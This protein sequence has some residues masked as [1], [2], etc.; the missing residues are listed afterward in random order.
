MYKVLL[1]DDEILDLEGMKTFIPWEELGLEVVGAVNSGFAAWEIID[2]QK[3]DILVT[4]VRMPNMTGL[5]LARKAI[6]RWDRLRVIFVSGYQDF[7]YL[8]QALTLNAYNYVLKPM[9][10]QELI[11]SLRKVCN[12]LDIEK[13]RLETERA[14]KQMAPIVKN[15]Y[16]IQILEGESDRETQ[17]ALGREYS[18]DGLR[19]PVRVAVFEIDDMTWK[20]EQTDRFLYSVLT[21][22][23]E[24]GFGWVCK[25]SRQRVAVL[26]EEG[27]ELTILDEWVARMKGM[28]PFSVTIGV[29]GEVSA[30]PELQRTYREALQALDFKMFKGKGRWIDY[31]DT[32][33]TEREEVRN[34]DIQLDSLFSSMANYELV[35]IHDELEQLFRFAHGLKS[36][37]S[38]QNFAMFLIMKLNDYLRS[39]NE[40]MFQLLELDLAKLDILLQFETIDDIH[41]W[42][43]RRVFEISEKLHTKSRGKHWKLVQEIIEYVGA[44][45]HENVTLRD[46]ADYFSFSPN[47]LGH[48]F[49][50]ETGKNF[51]D[52]I[53]ALRMERAAVLLKDTNLKIYEVADKVGYRYLPYFSRQFKETYGMKPMEYRRKS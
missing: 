20:P 24:R 19:W 41:S 43:R 11:E 2:R 9:D 10:D 7:N 44:R 48:L 40:D 22:C 38:I 21:L 52:T 34:L 29:G 16:L 45:L 14:Y 37:F 31:E 1:A 4:D 30:M 42:L 36:K 5:E 3:I 26:I 8:K 46:V 51:S 27:G 17:D 25:L 47:Y 33:G 39:Q 12:D 18:M 6:D 15:E 23:Q 49:K 50:E 32:R 28:L 13:A 53:I 35:N